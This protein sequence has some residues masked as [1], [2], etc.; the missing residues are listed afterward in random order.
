MTRNVSEM[1]RGRNKLLN[2][3]RLAGLISNVMRNVSARTV[4]HLWTL[5]IQPQISE[6][7]V[8][9]HSGLARVAILRASRPGSGTVR[10]GCLIKW[11]RQMPP[12]CWVR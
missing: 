10:R 5:Q 11:R 3:A 2:L 9:G 6:K 12:M 4:F 8:V 7:R 1:A